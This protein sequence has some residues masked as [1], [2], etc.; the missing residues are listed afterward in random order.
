MEENYD[1]IVCGTG[2]SETIL[3]GLLSAYGNKVL[4][5][6]KN[7]FY[8]GDT[9]SVNLTNLYKLF[10]NG[11]QPP[12]HLGANRDWNIDL[13]PKFIMAH[14]KLVKIILHTESVANNLEWKCVDGT[15]VM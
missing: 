6:D 15:Y 12:E 7:N 13:I 9:A 5:I 11:E 14:G 4:H 8:G 2:L 1:V 3:A 10:T